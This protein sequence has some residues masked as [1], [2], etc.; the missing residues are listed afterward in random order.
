MSIF[1]QRCFA[2]TAACLVLSLGGCSDYFAR[3]DME[4]TLAAWI[5][6]SPTTERAFAKPLAY[7]TVKK[8]EIDEDS[9]LAKSLDGTVAR[10]N[11]SGIGYSTEVSG[12]MFDLASMNERRLIFHR[13]NDR[14]TVR[15]DLKPKDATDSI[16]IAVST[17]EFSD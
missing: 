12:E 7:A 17:L 2:L 1:P 13:R 5:G 6:S 16:A 9:P 11:Q 10:L 8:D 14:L 15:I 3:R 4:S